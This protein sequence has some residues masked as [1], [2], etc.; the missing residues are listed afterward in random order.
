[1]HDFLPSIDGALV[2]LSHHGRTKENPAKGLLL[3]DLKVE[4]VLTASRCSLG[5][6]RIGDLMAKAEDRYSMPSKILSHGLS[7]LVRKEP[8]PGVSSGIIMCS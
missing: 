8:L 5:R 4:V 6:L 3:A 7:R 1:M 2:H